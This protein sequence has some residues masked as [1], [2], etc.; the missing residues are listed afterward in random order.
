MDQDPDPRP[1]RYKVDLQVTGSFKIFF[2]FPVFN[3]IDCIS[4]N[5][6][7][8]YYCENLIFRKH[9]ENFVMKIPITTNQILQTF[10]KST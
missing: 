6:K 9:F 2:P 5:R 10:A 8:L 7:I 4:R 1:G 3:F